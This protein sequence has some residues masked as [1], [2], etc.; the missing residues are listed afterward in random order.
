[1]H[2]VRPST[3]GQQVRPDAVSGNA[4]H[5][6]MYCY[7]LCIESV[8]GGLRWS[9]KCS[10][11]LPV[12]TFSVTRSGTAYPTYLYYSTYIVVMWICRMS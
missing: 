6:I 2:Q 5:H 7:T 8:A 3:A 1:M 10:W 12:R 11:V 9:E 4:M